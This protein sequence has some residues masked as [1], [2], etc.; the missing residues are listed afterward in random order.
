MEILMEIILPT[1]WGSSRKFMRYCLY[2]EFNMRS[3]ISSIVIISAI[4]DNIYILISIYMSILIT[5]YL[6]YLIII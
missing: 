2:N 6:T 4:N 3:G 1:Y 5:L